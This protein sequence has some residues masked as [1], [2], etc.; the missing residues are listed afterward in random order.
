[1]KKSNVLL[2]MIA[3][4]ILFTMVFTIPMHT[5]AMSSY[6]STDVEVKFKV[7]PDGTVE[8]AADYFYNY[9]YSYMYYTG[10]SSVYSDVEVSK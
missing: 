8:L 10:P 6:P 9:T 4:L 7:Y 3:S 5:Y 2:V 1:M